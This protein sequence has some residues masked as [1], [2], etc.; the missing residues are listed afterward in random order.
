MRLSGPITLPVVGT[1]DRRWLLAAGGAVAVVVGAAYL[2]QRANPAVVPEVDPATG[3]EADGGLYEN[4][5][6]VTQDDAGAGQF[7]TV[8]AWVEDVAQRLGQLYEPSWV[9]T[10]LGRWLAGQ[11]LTN[12]EADLVRSA[13][14]LRGDPPGGAPP[15]ILTGPGRIEETDPTR[16]P[17]PDYDTTP[18]G[19]PGDLG[20]GTRT[21]DPIYAE[22]A[23]P[24]PSRQRTY[25][26]TDGDSTSRIAALY[27]MSQTELLAAN[28]GLTAGTLSG[29][30]TI[31]IG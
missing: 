28:P 21:R 30:R 7:W 5:A 29:G 14:A 26:T 17:V 9:V 12:D 25:T 31:I 15:I 19:F 23:P 1:F 2:R 4:P 20:G 13:L 24:V 3:S 10:V 6:P 8:H 16:Y 22:S 18:P 27:G 11:P